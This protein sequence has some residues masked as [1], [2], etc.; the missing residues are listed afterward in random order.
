MEITKLIEAIKDKDQGVFK[1]LVETKGRA[2][3]I[4]CL[5]EII[6]R[7]AYFTIDGEGNIGRKTMNY[8]MPLAAYMEDEDKLGEYLYELADPREREKHKKIERMSG[9]DI[10]KL[11]R[12]FFKVVANNNTDF[13]KRYAKEMYLRDRE[14]FF[15]KLFNYVLLEGVDSQKALM[16]LALKKLTENGYS[17]NIVNTA[18]SYISQVKGDFSAYE[19][20]SCGKLSKEEVV[21]KGETLKGKAATLEELN[22]LAYIRVLGEYNY[23]NEERFVSVAEKALERA[24]NTPLSNYEK[25]IIKGL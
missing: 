5:S 25:E 1:E 22:T 10:E 12:N 16:A 23:P 18:M 9:E 20:P 2:G 14:G 19:N 13:A 6:G 15:K 4:E 7:R 8:A 17:D 11:Y 24:G 3:S 21:E